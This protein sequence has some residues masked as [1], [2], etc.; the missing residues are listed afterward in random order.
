MSKPKKEVRMAYNAK[1]I[2]IF[3]TSPGDVQKERGLTRETIHEWNM[4]NSV[5]RGIILLPVGWET[6]S[7]SSYGAPPQDDI[8]ETSQIV[9]LTDRGVLVET[10]YSN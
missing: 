5:A 7:V 6:D 3:I 9:R 10:G 1:V 2:R 4:L 8:N